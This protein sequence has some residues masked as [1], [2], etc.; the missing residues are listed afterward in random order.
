MHFYKLIMNKLCSMLTYY[1]EF[2]NA[3]SCGICWVEWQP[4]V[5]RNWKNWSS[6]ERASDFLT[7]RLTLHLIQL[8]Q[9]AESNSYVSSCTEIY[10]NTVLITH[11]RMLYTVFELQW[12]R[13]DMSSSHGRGRSKSPWKMCE[14]ATDAKWLKRCA[15]SA[16]LRSR[17]GSKSGDA[18]LGVMGAAKGTDAMMHQEWNSEKGKYCTLTVRC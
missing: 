9:N 11:V 1:F 17:S 4:D 18:G 6:H 8:R 14:T 15:S 16:S 12:R 5:Q 2:W 7:H 3:A 10:S 13:L